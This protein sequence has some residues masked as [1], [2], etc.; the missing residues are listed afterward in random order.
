MSIIHLV[1]GILLTAEIRQDIGLIRWVYY[2]HC[3]GIT[4]LVF[5]TYSSFIVT[6]L[7]KVQ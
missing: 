4:H 3:L 1:S 5:L 7:D 2:F 6:T